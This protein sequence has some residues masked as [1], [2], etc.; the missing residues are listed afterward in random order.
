M[1]RVKKKNRRPDRGPQ[2][3]NTVNAI[4]AAM[5]QC[6][7]H[8]AGVPPDRPLPVEWQLAGQLRDL[9]LALA[10]AGQTLESGVPSQVAKP[11]ALVAMHAKLISESQ[12][13]GRS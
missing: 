7:A 6:R 4:A 12:A 3:A 9:A 1:S 11:M 5:Q 10:Q 8:C 13:Q 2:P